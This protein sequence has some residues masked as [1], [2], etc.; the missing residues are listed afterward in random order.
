MLNQT[1]NP[2]NEVQPERRRERRSRSYLGARVIFNHR[3]SVVDCVVRNIS[4]S[5]A[6]AEFGDPTQVPA[7]FELHIP[8]QDR[9]FQGKLVWRNAQ[10][11]GVAL[12]PLQLDGVVLS[13]DD[14]RRLKALKA[15][16]RALR[17]KHS[18]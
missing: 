9:S 11:A 18:E 16:N 12:A 14:I 7:E 3:Q 2:E 5:G 10:A 4:T 17:K 1:Q 6:L 13:L 15:E 8:N